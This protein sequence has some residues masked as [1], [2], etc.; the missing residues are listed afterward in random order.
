MTLTSLELL[1]RQHIVPKF[2]KNTDGG[3]ATFELDGRARWSIEYISR[4]G[5][6]YQYWIYD[7]TTGVCVHVPHPD[8]TG[9]DQFLA[10]CTA[11][12]RRDTGLS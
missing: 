5:V 1:A 12:L 4:H 11:S 8:V 9:G 2:I 7:L 6:L 3:V 10:R